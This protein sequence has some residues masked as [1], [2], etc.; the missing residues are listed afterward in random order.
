MS[1]EKKDEN[2][3]PKIRYSLWA[4]AEKLRKVIEDDSIPYLDIP[5][6]VTGYA[7]VSWEGWGGPLGW[8][9]SRTDRILT[10]EEEVIMD[11]W[12]KDR[13][14]FATTVNGDNRVIE[15][16]E[17][18]E[19]KERMNL[20]IVCGDPSNG[21]VVWKGPRN[22]I[23]KV[24][25]RME[26]GVVMAYTGDSLLELMESAVPGC[27]LEHRFDGHNVTG[28]IYFEGKA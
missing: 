20:F 12:R 22:I 18:E 23:E 28:P 11:Y 19:L 25:V 26:S 5:D 9:P 27:S 13:A 3:K 6:A 1:S 2:G 15:P 14:A 4:V 21:K 16:S 8:Q 17:W 10:D 24:V 7:D